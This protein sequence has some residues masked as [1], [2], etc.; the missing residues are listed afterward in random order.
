MNRREFIKVASAAGFVL[1]AGGFS[2]IIRPTRRSKRYDLYTS[3]VLLDVSCGS[4]LTED[5]ISTCSCSFAV[6]DWNRMTNRQQETIWQI[7]E[8]RVVEFHEGKHR[9]PGLTINL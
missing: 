3:G 8:Q 9:K 5:R 4:I 1:A 7:M 6:D 2:A